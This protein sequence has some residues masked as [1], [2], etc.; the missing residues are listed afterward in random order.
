MLE[1][2]DYQYRLI[3]QQVAREFVKV[4]KQAVEK[5]ELM[6]HLNMKGKEAERFH[7]LNDELKDWER[8]KAQYFDEFYLQSKKIEE[9][10][11]LIRLNATL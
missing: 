1:D 4:K 6:S 9:N 7:K 10:D 2:L 8:T 3:D 5:Q 11:G